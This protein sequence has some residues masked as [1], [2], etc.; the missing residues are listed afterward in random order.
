MYLSHSPSS[1]VYPSFPPSWLLCHASLDMP[2]YFCRPCFLG[3]FV[4][5][6]AHERGRRLGK[7]TERT[8]PEAKGHIAAI[9]QTGKEKRDRGE[10][11]VCKGQIDGWAEGEAVWSCFMD[12]QA[13]DNLQT[14]ESCQPS[15]QSDSQ[16][17]DSLPPMALQTWIYSVSALCSTRRHRLQL[18]YLVHS[19]CVY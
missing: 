12:W 1:Y 8:T 7:K 15:L 3:P 13:V 4:S 11:R 5:I 9:M 2:L 6:A 18:I 10:K 14:P 19:V 16:W 17:G